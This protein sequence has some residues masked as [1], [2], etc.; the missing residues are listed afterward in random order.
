[1]LAIALSTHTLWILSYGMMSLAQQGLLGCIIPV[2]QWMYKKVYAV[3]ILFSRNIVYMF[4][5]LNF[6]SFCVQ[7]VNHSSAFWGFEDALH[8]L[9][10]WYWQVPYLNQLNTFIHVNSLWPSDAMWRQGSRSTLVQVM[11]CCL[12]APS[13]YLNQC[14]LI[15]TKVL[16]CSSEGN[17]T[18]DITAIS[19]LN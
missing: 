2:N 1:M 10:G 19:H 5:H 12:T 7:E 15:I 17:F 4:Y 13:R 3:S 18:W 16:W 6:V 11:A 8:M 9:S 14:W